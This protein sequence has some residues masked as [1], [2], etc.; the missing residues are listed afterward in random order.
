MRAGN[1]FVAN[2]ELTFEAFGVP[3]PQGSKRHV[4]NGR[5][6]E[7]SNVKPW[8][9]SVAQAAEKAIIDAG[10][11]PFDTAVVVSVVFFLPRPKTVKRLWP[12]V[13]P[14]TDKLQRAIGD[15]LSIDTDAV[16]TDDAKIV[17]WANPTKVY[18]DTREPG[19]WVK[20]RTATE[21]D[22]IE[23]LNNAS[24]TLPEMLRKDEYLH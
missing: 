15:A 12:D 14:D 23:A 20:I 16:L 18:A 6:V 13:A 19:V 17:K 3:R 4:G 2:Y 21:Q 24:I 9:V 5:L 10:L 1:I 7:A 22:L 11:L 8:R